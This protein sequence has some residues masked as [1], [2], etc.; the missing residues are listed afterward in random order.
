MTT[1]QHHTK[2]TS[3]AQLQ[4]RYAPETTGVCRLYELYADRVY[5]FVLRLSGSPSDAEDI[6]QEVF[7]A[8]YAG[9]DGFQGRARLLTWLL[10]IASRRWRDRCRHN[11]PTTPFVGRT[12]RA[13][14]RRSVGNAALP[15]SRCRERAYDGN[16]AGKT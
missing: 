5:G 14:S 7:L 1:H 11:L 2:Q 3:A 12:A 16:S 6:V 15:G 8:A 9:R 13:G 4:S 10:G